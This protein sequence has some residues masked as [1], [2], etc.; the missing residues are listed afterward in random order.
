MSD[1]FAELASQ[2]GELKI[3]KENAAFD[4]APS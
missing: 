1:I 3:L 2:L 4:M